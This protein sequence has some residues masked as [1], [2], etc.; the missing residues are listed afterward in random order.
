M[1]VTKYKLT[2][3]NLVNRNDTELYP[4][5][6]RWQPIAMAKPVGDIFSLTDLKILENDID[7]NQKNLSSVNI[8]HI[9]IKICTKI[10]TTKQKQSEAML[11]NL[12][13]SSYPRL[14]TARA[15]ISA[16]VPAKSG[17]TKLS[18]NNF[19]F[20]LCDTTQ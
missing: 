7:M 14:Y 1:K 11:F 4:G 13:L 8:N 2:E 12:L 16:R 6:C 10:T 9:S 18:H 3:Q 19:F 17:F 15:R 5:K 20:A